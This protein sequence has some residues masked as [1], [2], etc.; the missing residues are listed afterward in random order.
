MKTGAQQY[1]PLTE[2]TY[3]ILTALA[4][5]RHGYGIMQAVSELD[6]ESNKIGPGTMYGALAKLLDQGLIERAGDSQSGGERRKMYALT[7]LGRKVVELECGRM[8]TMAR[9]GRRLLEGAGE[10]R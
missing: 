6:G 3:L 1:L 4:E 2:A 7:P 10:V 9:L 5:P 8:E